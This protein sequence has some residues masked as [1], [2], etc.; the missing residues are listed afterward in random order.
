[1]SC[2]IGDQSLGPE[3]ETWSANWR[4]FFLAR[5]MFLFWLENFLIGTCIFFFS[6]VWFFERKKKRVL[7]YFHVNICNLFSIM[8]C[9]HQLSVL[10]FN[11]GAHISIKHC[12]FGYHP[13]APR[14]LHLRGATAYFLNNFFRVRKIC[15]RT[16]R[17]IFLNNIN[18][19][20]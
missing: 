4:L 9:T 20:M 12:I 3:L 8:V 13:Y 5:K 18:I 1:M 14:R 2:I 6:F 16:C 17:C 11:L 10:Y 15:K 19:E 7:D